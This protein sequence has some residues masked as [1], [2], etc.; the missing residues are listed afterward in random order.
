M[1]PILRV[2]L[3]LATTA[4]AISLGVVGV[5]ASTQCVRF[6]RE[7]VHHHRVSA[8]T[9]ARWAAWDKAHP[10]WHPKPTPKETWDKLNFACEV[11]VSAAP[12]AEDLPPLELGPPM[13]FP[14]EMT[15]PPEVPAVVASN[16]PPPLLFPETPGESL[17][18]PPIYAP[19]Y[20]SLY[21]GSPTS[22]VSPPTP[23]PEPATWTM[24]ATAMLAL[25]SLVW[26]RNRLVRLQRRA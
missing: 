22:N 18:S 19:E 16:T 3:V 12:V 2:P 5:H 24:I 6:I 21:G 7:K 4:C 9:A 15:A 17:V 23:A 8:A 1:K 10:N 25:S 11:P 26:R 13:A 14:L 20:P